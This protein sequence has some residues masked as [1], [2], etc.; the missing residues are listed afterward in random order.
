MITGSGAMMQPELPPFRSTVACP[1]PAVGRLIRGF[2]QVAAMLGALL[3]AAE[4]PA[5][6][7][8]EFRLGLAGGEAPEEAIAA[9]ECYRLRLETALGVPVRVVATP[10]YDGVVQGLL[11]GTVDMAWLGASA[12]AKI[13]LKDPTA[14]DVTLVKQ[15]TEGSTGYFSFAFARKDSGIKTIAD[16]R[17][18]VFAFG[19]PDSTSG[20]LVPEAELTET[21]GDLSKFFAATPFSGGHEKTIVGVAQGQF[22]AGV[23]SGDGLGSW[24]Q[25]FSSG[26]FRKAVDAG[27]V[28]MSKLA[29]LWQS[30][31]IPEGPLVIRR[32]VPPSVRDT[33]IPLTARLHETDRDCAYRVAGGK[34]RDFVPTTVRAYKSVITARRRQEEMSP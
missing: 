9:N 15:T 18:K 21:Y 27:V 26:A 1:G 16:A 34:A 4:A 20:Y 22:D 24:E 29:V 6:D 14:V 11:D 31:M 8:P 28:D 13:Y 10:S 2:A 19:E 33:V 5:A 25:G 12:F 3:C 32:A 7:L 23:S 17:G 30:R